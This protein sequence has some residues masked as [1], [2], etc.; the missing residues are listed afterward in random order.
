MS[1][2]LILATATVASA[3][4]A[5]SSQLL[6]TRA[7]AATDA[8]VAAPG[9]TAL[10]QRMRTA[11]PTPGGGRVESARFHDAGPAQLPPA[12]PG[13][14]TMGP[15][16]M[17]PAHCEVIGVLNEREGRDGQRYAI[18]FHLRLPQQ[19]NGRLLFQGGG[20]TNGELGDA[21]GGVPG[22]PAPALARGY[23]VLSQDS[24]HDNARNSDPAR[25]G[26]VAFGFDPQARADYGGLSLRPVTLAAKAAIRAFYGRAPR[27][28]YFNGCSKGGQ[29]G[30]FLAQRE[31]DLY[32][33]IVA[34]APGFA[35]PRA[36]V[37]ETYNT[38]AF[39]RVLRAQGQP[40]TIAALARSF[41]DGDLQIV[42]T[43]VL[44]A[45]DAADG[46][47]D[48]IVGAFRQCTS[49]R[50]LPALRKVTCTGAKTAQ[51]LS[52][53]Q[54]TALV[55]VHDGARDGK[56]RQL[57]PG[58]PWDAGWSDIGW[59]IWM[60]GSPDGQ[61]PAINVAMGFPS[62][63]AIFST[64]PTVPGAT[65][66]DN[67]QRALSFSMDRD[68]AAITAT[69]AHFPRSAWA[70][71]GARS[72]DLSAFGRRGGRL[73]VPHGVS[74]PVFSINDTIDWWEEMDRASHGR[75]ADVARVFPV[76]GMGHCR[77]GPATD[78]YDALEAVVRWVEQGQA[79]DSLAA[80]AGPMSPWPGRA[81]PLCRYPLIARPKPGASGDAADD[82]TCAAA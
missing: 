21:I 49:A 36:A 19:W 53:D 61:V 16:P 5:G 76:P 14:M 80:V 12:P 68:A 82:F 70:M 72:P 47:R 45:C 2:R 78:G 3:T 24:G 74:D 17:L 29:E 39:A 23:A 54:V 62:L 48:S 34:A 26:P 59:R 11:W 9:C 31:P 60:L 35:L 44:D 30:M 15:P 37:A 55:A 42:R 28:S 63:S 69:D 4:L 56:G 79:P 71:I 33:G 52:P 22:G 20:G 10:A 81:R 7:H 57:Y 50:V 38:Q 41:T 75:A 32:D 58:F 73:I 27:H 1:R 13:M 77:G 6:S 67:F 8:G 65:P 46:R 18:R 51:C 66:Q 64:P 40:L 25:G 43:A